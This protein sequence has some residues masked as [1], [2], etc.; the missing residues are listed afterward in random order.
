MRDI[1]FIGDADFAELEDEKSVITMLSAVRCIHF[2]GTRPRN[3]R[4]NTASTEL[5]A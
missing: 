5:L 2:R 3:A 4:E 1:A